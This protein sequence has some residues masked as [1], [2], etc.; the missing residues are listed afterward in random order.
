MKRS[1]KMREDRAAAIKANKDMLAKA[2]AEGREMTAEETASFQGNLKKAEAIRANIM[3]MEQQEANESEAPVLTPRVVTP[4]LQPA[5]VN[6]GDA[7]ANTPRVYGRLRHVA[8]A[9]VAHRLGVFLCAVAGMPWAKRKAKDLWAPEAIQQ[10]DVNVNGGYLVPEEFENLMI[11]LR[12]RYGVFRRNTKVVPMASDVKTLPRRATGLT[13]YWVG[14]TTAITE[15]TKTWNTVKLVAKKL[16]ALARSTNELLE[17]SVVNIGDDLAG[18]VAYAFAQAEDQAG[19]N[20]DGTSTYGGITG[21]RAKLLGLDA[22]IA[23]IAGL[24]VGT[25]NQYSELILNDFINTMALLPQYADTPDCKWYMHKSFYESVAKRLVYAAGGVTATEINDGVRRQTLL[26]YP[27]EFAQV[28]PKTE[29]NS[30]VCAL[31]G[32]L[33]LASKLGDRRSTTLAMT[34]EGSVGGVSTF[35]T[36][37]TAWRGTERLDIVVHD[38]G[39][40]SATAAS[41]QAGPVV[42]LITAAS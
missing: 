1:Q 12:E 25:G 41:R 30:Q 34:Q 26:G 21:A 14:E 15:S 28:L 32:S 13:A 37:E 19:F 29:A 11:D 16:A 10:E 23:N 7:P 36:D 35:E 2:D 38:V 39:N 20:G 18:E 33:P 3:D 8:D 24:F 17:D 6:S 27:V 9:K 5:I 4:T 31:F 42:G 22:T 40:A